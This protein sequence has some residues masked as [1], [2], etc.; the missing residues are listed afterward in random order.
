M[1]KQQKLAKIILVILGI[2]AVFVIWNAREFLYA[3]FIFAVIGGPFTLLFA[4]FFMLLGIVIMLAPLVI[5]YLFYRRAKFLT[6]SIISIVGL[7]ILLILIPVETYLSK[8][9]APIKPYNAYDA[10][11]TAIQP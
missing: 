5:A 1:E 2:C 7:I 10:Y 8:S 6:A 9:S 4:T 3:G 11:Q